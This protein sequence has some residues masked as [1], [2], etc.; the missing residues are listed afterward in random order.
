M[1][2]SWSADGKNLAVMSPEV[3]GTGSEWILTIVSSKT[4]EIKNLRSFKTPARAAAWLPDGRGILVVALDETGRGQI[5]FVSYPQGEV[6]RF[7]NDLANYNTCCLDVSRDGD[8]LVAVQDAILSDV[9]VAKGDG[10]EAKQISSGEPLGLG[11]DWVG[12]KIAAVNPRLQWIAM[13]ADGSNQSQLTNDHDLH[14]Q[15]S[16]CPDG[17]QL[18]YSTIHNG[19]LDL[20]RAQADGSSPV[21]LPVTG[22][23]FG[24]ALCS[25]DSKSAVY[26]AGNAMW[27]ISLEGGK[28]E[29]LNVPLALA[30][31]SR[32][33]KLIFYISQTHQDTVMQSKFVVTSATGGPSLYT[34]DVP[35]GMQS[36]EFTSD[37]KAIAFLL[38]RDRAT[39]IWEQPLAGGP[40][41]QLTKFPSG[42]MFA[43]AW[44]ADGKQLAFSRGQ[45][46]T[47]VVMMSNFH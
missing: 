17:K 39:N 43:F 40:L 36:P 11:L 23:L 2:V 25:P 34:F 37:G 28:P 38:T 10:S 8:S 21:K 29:K 41:V 44:S 7:T 32:D 14:L 4:G 5:W 16:A 13:N 27:S 19:K 47:D 18:V 9:W 35:Y 20:W 24:G 42:Q 31:Y 12:N 46:K 15:L 1:N 33:A 6:S 30:G 3:V 45:N 26:A 22:L